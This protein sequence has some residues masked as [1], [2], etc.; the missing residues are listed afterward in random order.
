M[1][2]NPNIINLFQ[3]EHT[4]NPQIPGGIEVGT[5]KMAVQSQKAV[6][7]LKRDK[8]LLTIYTVI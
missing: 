2:A 4:E 3:E 1:S 6:I 8:L 5:D 7:S